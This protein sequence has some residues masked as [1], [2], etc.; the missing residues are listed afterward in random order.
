MGYDDKEVINSWKRKGYLNNEKN[1][2]T[3]TVK[4]NNVCTKCIIMD[5]QRD[6]SKEEQEDCN[7]YTD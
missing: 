2:N 7:K 3:R 6:I 4:I 5:M 1:R